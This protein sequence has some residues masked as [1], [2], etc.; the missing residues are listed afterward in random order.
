MFTNASVSEIVADG[1]AVPWTQPK[2][3]AFASADNFTYAAPESSERF[4]VSS[5]SKPICW[6]ALNLLR[7]PS[8]FQS[9]ARDRRQSFVVRT[10]VEKVAPAP[11]AF[12]A[13]LDPAVLDGSQQALVRIGAS[14]LD[15][16]TKQQL[17]T[18]IKVIL[19]CSK[20]PQAPRLVQGQT[21]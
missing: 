21:R 11:A 4:S 19:Q 2:F 1:Q 10:Q 12:F 16:L 15:S 9:S 18:A 17:D 6:L 8:P 14:D 7:M 13:V 5:S 20:R 3:S